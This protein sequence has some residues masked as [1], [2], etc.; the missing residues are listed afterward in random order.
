MLFHVIAPL[1]SRN[2]IRLNRLNQFICINPCFAPNESIDIVYFIFYARP[3]FQRFKI[4]HSI[5]F[6]IKRLYDFSLFLS[7]TKVINNFHEN[8]ENLSHE[9]FILQL[10]LKHYKIRLPSSGL[11]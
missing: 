3:K 1:Y 9:S 6:L 2:H 7:M 4:E 10:K 8:F 11:Y 5:K